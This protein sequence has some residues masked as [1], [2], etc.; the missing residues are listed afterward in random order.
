[1]F[2]FSVALSGLISYFVNRLL[3]SLD[4]SQRYVQHGV[5]V[6][7]L[8]VIFAVH[9][10]TNDIPILI[11]YYN[12]YKTKSSVLQAIAQDTSQPPVLPEEV[13]K[14]KPVNNPGRKLVKPN[15]KAKVVS[16]DNIIA[17]NNQIEQKITKHFME[18]KESKEGVKKRLVKPNYSASLPERSR[19]L[20]V[21]STS[22]QFSQF[23]E[24]SSS[25]ATR[26]GSIPQSVS[27]SETSAIIAAQNLEYEQCLAADLQRKSEV[28][29]VSLP[30]SNH[31]T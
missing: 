12:G 14:E 7:V 10:Y 29:Q 24:L 3:D 19:Y 8:S 17:L 28:A 30:S 16:S 15:F 6:L 27:S 23:D 2:L 31:A 11:Q 13:V 9:L 21:I 18:S 25:L 22:L 4:D 26:N 5:V 20:P 1:M